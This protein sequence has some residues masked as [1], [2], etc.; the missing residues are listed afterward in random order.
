MLILLDYWF[1]TLNVHVHIQNTYYVNNMIIIKNYCD[2]DNDNI[3]M[4]LQYYTLCMLYNNYV[5]FTV[6]GIACYSLATFD[7]WMTIMY[8]Y[9]TFIHGTVFIS[10]L[11]NI[12]WTC[13]LHICMS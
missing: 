2:N 3:T 6:E 9:H 1:L 4:A 7:C 5:N 8:S 11:F 13:D 10:L 12:N